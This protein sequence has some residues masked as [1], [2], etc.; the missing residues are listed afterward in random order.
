MCFDLV[1]RN[2]VMYLQKE[3][4]HALSLAYA[5]I[6]VWNQSADIESHLSPIRSS[7]SNSVLWLKKGS[8]T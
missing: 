6:T 3:N 7:V 8:R 5:D 1:V 2:T 4:A